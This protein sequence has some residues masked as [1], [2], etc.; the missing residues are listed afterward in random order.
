MPRTYLSLGSIFV[1]WI[2]TTSAAADDAQFAKWSKVEFAFQGPTS[3][4]RGEPNPFAI[5]LEN[6]AGDKLRAAW[7]DARGTVPDAR[8]PMRRT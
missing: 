7:F 6:L 4:G 2:I 3:P 5:K 8:P 1:A